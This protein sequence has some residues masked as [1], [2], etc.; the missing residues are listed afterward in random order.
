MFTQTYNKSYYNNKNSTY[1]KK[2]YN[3]ITHYLTEL[4]KRG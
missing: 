1:Y 3:N 4:N 2:E